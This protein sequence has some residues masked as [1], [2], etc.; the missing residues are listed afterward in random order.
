[1]LPPRQPNHQGLKPPHEK[2]ATPKAY[3][4]DK[5]PKWVDGIKEEMWRRVAGVHF[6]MEC[7]GNRYARCYMCAV[8]DEIRHMEIDHVHAWSDTL[9]KLTAD[10]GVEAERNGYPENGK[11]LFIQDKG[12]WK[13]T[14]WAAIA[15][16]NDLDNLMFIHGGSCNQSKTDA[17]AR[18]AAARNVYSQYGDL[19]DILEFYQYFNLLDEIQPSQMPVNKFIDGLAANRGL[20]LLLGRMN[21]LWGENEKTRL[22]G[23]AREAA[24]VQA[25]QP[26]PA[27]GAPVEAGFWANTRKKPDGTRATPNQTDSMA[28][29]NFLGSLTSRPRSFYDDMEVLYRG[30]TSTMSPAMQDR[31]QEL[32]LERIRKSGYQPGQTKMPLL[33]RS[34]SMGNMGGGS[35]QSSSSSSNASPPPRQRRGRSPGGPPMDNP[36][37]RKGE[38]VKKLKQGK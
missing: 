29:A 27:P 6:A 21:A 10:A 16:S 3:A 30:S 1:M 18:E 38:D 28:Q 23:I 13:P 25:I 31:L 19:K 11:G 32:D 8:P 14:E 15:Y 20:C 2:E 22:Q 35:D 9:A 17:G 34:P 12:V 33:R 36:L 26:L 37:D 7:M 24:F 5:R 4:G